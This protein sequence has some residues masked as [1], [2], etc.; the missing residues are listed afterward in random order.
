[1]L[2]M[3]YFV[4]DEFVHGYVALI[5]ILHLREDM[6]Q[7]IACMMYHNRLLASPPSIILYNEHE[8]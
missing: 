4:G 6:Q 3:L 1:M 7:N 2:S 8:I 5:I